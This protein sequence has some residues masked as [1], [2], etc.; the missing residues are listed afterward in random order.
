[1]GAYAPATFSPRVKTRG[2]KGRK[3]LFALSS[4]LRVTVVGCALDGVMGD[5]RAWMQHF[6]TTPSWTAWR[7]LGWATLA[8]TAVGA[9]QGFSLSMTEAWVAVVLTGGLAGGS[10][11]GRAVFKSDAMAETCALFA[12]WIAMFSVLLP[13]SYVAAGLGWPLIDDALIVMDKAVGFDWIAFQRWT[14]ETPAVANIF[15]QFY[16]FSV[17]QIPLAVFCL[18]AR[19]EL[20]RLD[21]YFTGL[22]I[23]AIAT[24][25]LS[26]VLPSLGAHPA[27]GFEPNKAGAIV[28]LVDVVHYLPDVLALRSGA[29]RH[30]D[31]H[32]SGIITFPSFHTVMAVTAAWATWHVRWLGVVNAAVAVIVLVTTLPIGGHHLMDVVGGVGI[33]AVAIYVAMRIEGRTR[34]RVPSVAA[35]PVTAPAIA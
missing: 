28:R 11:A 27:Y 25:V 3:L 23:S 4:F 20:G 8:T 18:A 21:V 5:M 7:L 6:P 34:I 31:G 16:K 19:R 17:V 32:F 2:E 14:D 26:G 9:W 35:T 13:A 1:L 10:I 29:L 30:L 22:L 24:I 12:F 33:S 15:M